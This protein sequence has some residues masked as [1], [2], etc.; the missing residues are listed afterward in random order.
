MGFLMAIFQLVRFCAGSRPIFRDLK[1]LS[2]TWYQVFE[3][4]SFF[5][6]PQELYRC[7]SSPRCHHCISLHGQTISI[8]LLSLLLS[9][10]KRFLSSEED[11]LFFKVTLD[12]H[13]IILI[14]LR[15]NLNNSASFTVQVLLSYSMTLQTHA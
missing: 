3:V 1:S 9:R 15:P 11:F 7:I 14:S 6:P 8:C 5:V 2:T 10:P 4:Y 13:L 12:I